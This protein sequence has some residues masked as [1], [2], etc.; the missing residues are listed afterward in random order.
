MQKPNF[1]SCRKRNAKQYKDTNFD[2]EICNFNWKIKNCTFLI[3]RRSRGEIWRGECRGNRCCADDTTDTG[4]SIPGCTTNKTGRKENYSILNT[5]IHVPQY[6]V[7]IKEKRDCLLANGFIQ[8]IQ[9]VLVRELIN[10]LRS[11]G[12]SNFSE[13]A[14]RSILRLELVRNSTTNLNNKRQKWDVRN[15]EGTETVISIYLIC[16]L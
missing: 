2:G 8:W 3:F 1:L 9:C 5:R 15:Q 12:N 13:T 7:R 10:K 16:N 4:N 6:I 14:N 11:S